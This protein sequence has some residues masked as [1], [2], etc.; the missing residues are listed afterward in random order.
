[1]THGRVLVAEARAAA[2]RGLMVG[3]HGYGENAAS[4]WSG[5][6]RFRG[7]GVDARLDSGAAPLLRPSDRAGDRLLDDPRGSGGRHCRQP[8][9]RHRGPGDRSLTTLRNRSSLRAS[10]RVWR[11][12]TGRPAVVRARPPASSRSVAM[13]RRSCCRI[14]ESTFP[15]VLMIRGSQ[16]RVVSPAEIRG[17]YGGLARAGCRT[18]AAPV[19]G[20][21]EWHDPVI[22]AAARFIEAVGGS[23]PSPRV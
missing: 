10:L 1:M 20:G 3:F 2:A 7:G 6:G 21:H 17:R 12:P 15:R 16:G 4:R 14:L 8:L 23:R 5:C 18:A 19:E 22:D 13:Y 11:W 9:L